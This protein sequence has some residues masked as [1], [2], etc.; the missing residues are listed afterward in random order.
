MM[1]PD[2]DQKQECFGWNTLPR[3]LAATAVRRTMTSAVVAKTRSTTT[4]NKRLTQF[5]PPT[6]AFHKFRLR[7]EF[8]DIPATHRLLLAWE[9]L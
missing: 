8:H 2:F 4:A 6:S 7:H 1:T 5:L 3:L 9:G